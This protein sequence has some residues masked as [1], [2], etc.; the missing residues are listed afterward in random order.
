MENVKLMNMCKIIDKT[1]NKVLVQQRVKKW[2][3][4]A[5]PGGKIE[6]GES[7]TKSVIREVNEETGL[8]IDN[9][10]LCGIKDWYSSEK[11]ERSIVLLY[12]TSDFTGT[13]IEEME[14][15]KNFWVD[16][17]DIAKL[18]LADNF[19]KVLKIYSEDNLSEMIYD[20]NA[21]NN[22]NLL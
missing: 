18:E 5:F 10:K 8:V 3:G 6:K 21:V 9:L 14:E 2:T 19:D 22:W 15:G 7:I 13:L 17:H 16:E 4:I 1:N 12:E 20:K 11:N